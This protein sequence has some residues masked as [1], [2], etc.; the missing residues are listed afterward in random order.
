MNN[1]AKRLLT[2]KQTGRLEFKAQKGAVER[3]TLLG[4]KMTQRPGHSSVKRMGLQT[5]ACESRTT[6]MHFFIASPAIN[7]KFHSMSDGGF[8]HIQLGP[9]CY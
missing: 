6:A 3:A 7:R 9:G 8:G 4:F 1:H 5:L 2:W